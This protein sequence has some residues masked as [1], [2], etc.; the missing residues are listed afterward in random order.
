MKNL[1][2][3]ISINEKRV[4]WENMLEIFKQYIVDVLFKAEDYV[5]MNLSQRF[6]QEL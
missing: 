4:L 3:S 1:F 2:S 6:Y 5:Y